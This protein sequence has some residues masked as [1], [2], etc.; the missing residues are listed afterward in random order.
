MIDPEDKELA[1]LDDA[2]YQREL[3]RVRESFRVADEKASKEREAE[4]LGLTKNAADILEAAMNPKKII[5]SEKA[6]AEITK[7]MAD[8]RNLVTPELSEKVRKLTNQTAAKPGVDIPAYRKMVAAQI[9][10]LTYYR[11]A[12]HNFYFPV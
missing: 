6:Q 2:M 8:L 12:K 3:L 10:E 4:G 9:R 7:L 5:I 1:E 11:P